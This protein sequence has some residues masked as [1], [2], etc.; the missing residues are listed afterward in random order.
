MA[1][2]INEIKSQLTFGGARNSLFQIQITNPANATADI[3][4]P[5]LC[6]AGQIPASTLGMIEVPY[7][8]RKVKIAGDRIFN[9]WT[10]TIINDEDFA[11]RNAMEEWSNSINGHETNLTSF[12]AASPNLYKSNATVQQFSKTGVALR[13]YQFNGIF[14]MEVSMIDMSWETVDTIE[15]F[16]VTFMYDSWEISGGTTGNAGIA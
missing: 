4:V 5:F 9:E 13:T 6:K 12:G 11:I 1:F 7:F 15:E 2:N 10:V 8:G 3:K 16:T 14:P